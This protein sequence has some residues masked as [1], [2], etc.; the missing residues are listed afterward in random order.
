[1][2]GHGAIK[3]AMKYAD[4]FSQ[5]GSLSGSPMSIRFRRTT[6]RATL[7]NHK[8]PETVKQLTEEISYE[9]N[10]NLAAAYAKAAAFSPNPSKPPMYLDLPFESP[11]TDED[12]P[13]WQRWW[14]DDPLALVSRSS[15]GLKTLDQIYIDHG[16]DETTLGTEDFVRE[17]VRYGIGCTYHVFRGDH[18]DKMNQRYLRMLQFFSLRWG[19]ER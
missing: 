1:M 11:A 12:D 16:D 3:L 10:W 4:V 17:L 13:V 18:V 7:L 2:G 15:R 14:D 8:K 5:V 19:K 9:K 6:Y